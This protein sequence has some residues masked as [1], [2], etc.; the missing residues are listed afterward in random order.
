M[1]N[2]QRNKTSENNGVLSRMRER[3]GGGSMAAAAISVK[4]KSMKNNS[5]G[6]IA[7][8]CENQRRI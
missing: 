8:R 5:A 2:N 7:K 1:A 4:R 3:H 6:G